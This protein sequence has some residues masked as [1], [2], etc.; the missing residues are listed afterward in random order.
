MAK[1]VTTIPPTIC[2]FT[3]APINSTAKRKVAGYAR[4]STDHE[5][6]LSS[7]EAQVDYYTNYIK[8]HDDWEFVDIYT[9]EGITATS[10][11]KRAGFKQMIEDALAGKIDLIITKSVS[12][13]A[14]NTVDSLTNIRKLKENG[15]E[16]FFEKENIWTLDAKGEL[17]LTIMSS[18]AQEEARNISENTTWGQRKRF[19]DGR[20]SLNYRYFLGYDRKPGPDGGLVINEE[21]AKIVRDIYAAFLSGMSFYAIAK[22]L[23]ARGI[24]PLRSETWH[25]NTIQG[26]LTNEKY[27]GDVLLQKYYTDDYLTKKL[28]R[29][30]GEV[31]QY[32][33]EDDHEAII[34]PKVFDLVQAEI[35]RRTKSGSRYSG[36]DIFAS[37]IRCGQ[38]GG[39]YGA[40]V[41]HSND[42]YRRVV[43]RCNHKYGNGKTCDTPT[44][45]EDEI[46]AMFV[47]A[48]NARI[49]DLDRTAADIEV[50]IEIVNDTAALETERDG[51]A[52]E[53]EIVTGM[54]NDM[55]AENAHRAQDQDEYQRR[56][57]AMVERYNAAE[58]RYTEV[59]ADIENRHARYKLISHE[60]DVLKENAE[61]LTEFDADIWGATVAE[62]VVYGPD[63][64]RFIFKHE[65]DYTVNNA[66]KKN[67]QTS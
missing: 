43:Y 27:R 38:C 58:K 25:A 51:L 20:Y 10:T 22:D 57:N 14:R 49:A 50:L 30:H 2:R 34:E 11:K 42:K 44:F 31:Q 55:I 24:K 19:A 3:A 21:Q 17:L 33:I 56:Y 18:L 52:G 26:I 60:L 53:L 61:P 46:K 13:F 47:R 28:K 32:Y 54:I 8:S 62:A 65:M 9:D 29:N 6:Q 64:V 41:W 45:T 63:D 7:Y 23:Q 59:C 16:V 67:E 48:Y 1:K 15:I 36:V 66:N 5:D 35:A 40:K 37:K 12:R 39:W 4:V